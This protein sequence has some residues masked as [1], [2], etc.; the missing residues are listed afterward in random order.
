MASSPE[1]DVAIMSQS[2]MSGQEP[3]MCLQRPS[4]ARS[5][6]VRHILADTFRQL[7]ARD[8]V[9]M[10]T[11]NYLHQSRGSDDDYHEK[12]VLALKNVI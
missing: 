7:Y 8:I 5:Q 2:E 3:V 4:S 1:G 10:D 9:G 6:D 12:Y 11:V